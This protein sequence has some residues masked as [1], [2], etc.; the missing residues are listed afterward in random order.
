MV[1]RSADDTA[2][3]SAVRLA[4]VI[5]AP[6]HFVRVLVKVPTANPMMD[7]IFGSA[8][9]AEPAFSLVHV[10]AILGDIL[11]A[12]VDPARIVGGV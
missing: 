6:S 4:P 8:E 12:V 5:L 7:T 9:A 2:V 1:E 11:D 10:R 3:L